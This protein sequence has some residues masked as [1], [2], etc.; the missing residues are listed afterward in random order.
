MKAVIM[1]GGEGKRLRPLTCT[2]PKPMSKILGKPILEYIFDLLCVNGVTDAAVTL[3]YMP[4]IIERKYE[5]GYK[6]LNLNFIKEDEP[7]GTAG[8]VKNAA[9]G[10]DEPFVV[11]SG[12]A[13]CD[14]DLEKIMRFHKESNSKLTIA[15]THSDNPR[16]Y[17]VIKVGEHNRVVGF[18]EKPSWNQAISTLA[19]TGVYIINPECLDMIPDGEN[20]DFASDLFPLMLEKDMPV[21]CY[22]TDG[23]W[24]DIGS[25][26]AYIRCQRDMFDG[27][28][29]VPL[30]P[31]TGGIYT[32]NGLPHGDY[33]I[34]PPVY[35]GD[36]VEIED[37]AVIGPYSVID[38]NCYIGKNAKTGYSVILENSWLA[39]GAS[40]IGA[41][42]CSG[43]AL[44]KRA[45]M[46]EGSVAGSGSVIGE[47]AIVNSGVRIWPGKIVGN[48]ARVSQNIKYGS[49]KQ[50]I[51]GDNGIDE[52]NGARLN[53]ETCVR[54]GLAVG[55][56]RNGRKSGIAIDGTRTAEVMQLALMSGLAGS[57]SAVWNFGEC[58]ESQL[59]FLVNFCGLGVG[60]FVGAKEE[61]F[62]KICGEGGLTIPRFFERE[63]ENT[64]SNGEFK[65]I[66]EGNIKEIYDMSGLKLLYSQELMK[67]APYGLNGIGVKFLSDNESIR[68]LLENCAFRLGA[69]ENENIIF[70]ID[71]SGTKLRVHNGNHSYD[72]NKMLAVCCFNEMRNGRDIAV[73]YDAPVF[74]D[75]LAEECGRKAFRYLTTPADNSDSVARRL[76]AKQI[77]VRDALFLSVKLLSIM[78]E[79]ECPIEVL[80]SEIPE[81][82]IVK[83]YFTV[84]FSTADLSGFIGEEKVSIK[85]DFEGIRLIRESGKLL[86][87]PEKNG[88][89]VK[90]LA[91]ADS[92]EA[93]DEL[94][95]SVEEMIEKAS[96]LK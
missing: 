16:E 1:A 28:I 77:F 24:C 56:T 36:N 6:N 60:L 41:V 94:C 68:I 62:V 46:F 61:K 74:L 47:N 50:E 22:H 29:N 52:K 17:G 78:K 10:Y 43:V 67:Q 85:N 20:F 44:K 31:T 96:E 95:T 58:F 13:L 79:R 30:N 54:L 12:D 72:Y 32:A 8:S 93:A 57:G 23:Y 84:P 66:S 37:G 39:S 21:F 9:S 11:I 18:I 59:N 82:Y 75:T 5:F 70:E 55:S 45:A 90:V 7:L 64:M 3:G 48:G 25:T 89:K 49:F 14:F 81:K 76:A 15:A 4:H 71:S 91:E 86:I 73:P 19:N 40:V 88:E 35:I 83:K 42:V 26:D 51:L 87:I 34:V 80:V 2:L 63:I 38:D 69:H 92:M 65:E 27:K 33:N 53:T